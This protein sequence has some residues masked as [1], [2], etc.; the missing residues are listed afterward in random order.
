MEEELTMEEQ[1]ALRRS[2][3]LKLQLTPKYQNDAADKLISQ[4]RIKLGEQ[5]SYIDELKDNLRI[6]KMEKQVA[7]AQNKALQARIQKVLDKYA[8]DMSTLL[9]EPVIAKIQEE[10]KELEKEIESLKKVRDQLCYRLNHE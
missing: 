7:E 10:K 4:L 3:L 6:M 1:R 2:S 5:E 8:S 9:R